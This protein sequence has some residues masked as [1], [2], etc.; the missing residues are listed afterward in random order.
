MF[1]GVAGL[2]EVHPEPAG[3]VAVHVL[4]RGPLT[5]QRS[6]ATKVHRHLPEPSGHVQREMRVGELLVEPDVAGDHRDRAQVGR[7]VE[8]AEQNRDAVV[9]GG[10]GVDDQRDR[11]HERAPCECGQ[12]ASSQR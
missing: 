12:N 4:G 11:R 8:Q 10:V 2:G 3:A 9:L 1:L 6:P 7:R 5:Q